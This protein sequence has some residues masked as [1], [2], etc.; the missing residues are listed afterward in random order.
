MFSETL[1]TYERSADPS[2][3]GG[4]GSARKTISDWSKASLRS[5]V[6]CK[7]SA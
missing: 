5:V 3:P 4:V 7:R 2:S 1:R 6:K